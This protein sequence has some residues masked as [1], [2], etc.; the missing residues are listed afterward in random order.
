MVRRAVQTI[1]L[2]V[3][4]LGALLGTAPANAERPLVLHP[5]WH[6]IPASSNN[7]VLTAG[8]Y[9]YIGDVNSGVLID[10]RT[11][12]RIRVAP[13]EGYYV[14][15]PGGASVGGHWLMATCDSYLTCQSGPTYQLYD[16]RARGWK[17]LPP[18]D[19]SSAGGYGWVPVAIGDYWIHF[20]GNCGYHCGPTLDAFLNIQSGQLIDTSQGVVAGAGSELPDLDSPLLGRPICAPLTLPEG[21]SVAFYGRFAVVRGPHGTYLERCGSRLRRSVGRGLA[22]A[23]NAHTVVWMTGYTPQSSGQTPMPL[24]L[25]G[26]FLPTLRRFMLIMPPRASLLALSA[27]HIYAVTPGPRSRLYEAPAP[28]P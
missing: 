24:P 7:E 27:R 18:P 12:Q 2:A 22:I 8:R 16:I 25:R 28:R 26:L 11:G 14:G 23:A 15:T 1:L 13:P 10:E 6:R 21:S 5:K 17:P 9:V 19:L 4:S 3:V 20:T